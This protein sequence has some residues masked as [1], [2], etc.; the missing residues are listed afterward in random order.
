MSMHEALIRAMHLP[1]DSDTVRQLHE[2]G[3]AIANVDTMSQAIH[4]VYCG[5]TADHEHPNQKD[6]DQAMAMIE[7]LQRHAATPTA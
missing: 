4:D 5:I 1:E 6:H 7:A 2:V 3:L